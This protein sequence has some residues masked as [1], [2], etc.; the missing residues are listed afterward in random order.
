MLDVEKYKTYGGSAPNTVRFESFVEFI[1]AYREFRSTEQFKNAFVY[2]SLESKEACIGVVLYTPTD[3]ATLLH[4]SD[5]YGV[6]LTLSLNA[7]HQEKLPLW[8]PFTEQVHHFEQVLETI[9]K[10]FD[11]E[12]KNETN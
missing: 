2:P 10:Q 1:A 3:S 11:N 6:R 7:I 5:Y 8:Q 9:F 12:V 4:K